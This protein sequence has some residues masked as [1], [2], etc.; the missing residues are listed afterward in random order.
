MCSRSM[1]EYALIPLADAKHGAGVR[2]TEVLDIAH[3]DREALVG[4]K[5]GDGTLDHSPGLLGEQALLG[6]IPLLGRNGPLAP[7]GPLIVESPRINCRSQLVVAEVGEGDGAPLA[8][9]RTITFALLTR[10]RQIQVLSDD[11]S[12]NRSMP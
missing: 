9:G 10:I 12:S 6:T 2:G 3:G 4:R 5:V 8:L 1:Q 11:L 7:I